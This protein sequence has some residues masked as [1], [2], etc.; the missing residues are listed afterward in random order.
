LAGDR[1][2]GEIIIEFFS[3]RSVLGEIIIDFFCQG[4]S[5]LV[6]WPH[7]RRYFDCPF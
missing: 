2:P 4:K 1:L 5:P 6:T 3:K 7:Q